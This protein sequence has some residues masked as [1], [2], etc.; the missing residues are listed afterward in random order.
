MV[1]VLGVLRHNEIGGG[2]QVP[3]PI[4][5]LGS[6][7]DVPVPRLVINRDRDSEYPKFWVPITQSGRLVIEADNLL[8]MDIWEHTIFAIKKNRG[9]NDALPG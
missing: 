6:L 7:A 2:K 4:N 3:E 9:G 8:G 1:F 5:Y